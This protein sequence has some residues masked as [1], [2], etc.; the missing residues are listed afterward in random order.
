MVPQIVGTAFADLSATSA[1]RI[2]TTPGAFCRLV[3]RKRVASKTAQP[4]FSGC[5]FGD[6]RSASDCLRHDANVKSVRCIVGDHDAGTM[7][8]FNAREALDAVGLI[9]ILPTT[10]RHAEEELRAGAASFPTSGP[11]PATEHRRLVDRLNGAL[12]GALAA[13]PGSDR[14]AGITAA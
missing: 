7:S 10:A 14:R 3:A 4:L 6:Q 5:E 9:A 13:S 8:L 12:R 2:V 11:L 1:K